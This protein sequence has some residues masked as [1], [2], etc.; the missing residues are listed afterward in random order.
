LQTYQ[1][2][3]KHREMIQPPMRADERRL[4]TSSLSAFICG[5]F[6]FFSSLLRHESTAPTTS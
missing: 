6:A 1:D 4:K 3:E 5:L 2:A